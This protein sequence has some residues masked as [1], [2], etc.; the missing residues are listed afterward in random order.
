VTQEIGEALGMKAA[1]NHLDHLEAIESTDDI[2]QE[3]PEF[4][5]MLELCPVARNAAAARGSGWSASYR[6]DPTPLGRYRTAKVLDDGF[7][8]PADDDGAIYPYPDE[9]D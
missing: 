4:L 8:S 5:L 1:S 2:G 9:A 6:S 3:P 7:V